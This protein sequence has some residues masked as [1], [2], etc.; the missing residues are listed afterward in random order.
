MLLNGCKSKRKTWKEGLLKNSDKSKK[1][2]LLGGKKLTFYV[3]LKETRQKQFFY[4]P[5]LAN[6]LAN[7]SKHSRYSLI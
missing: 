6:S 4:K 5:L 1:Y 3:K 2:I 7:T